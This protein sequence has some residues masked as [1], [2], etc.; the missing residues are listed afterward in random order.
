[1]KP[2]VLSLLFA[3]SSVLSPCA[4][5]SDS[6]NVVPF[7][8]NIK[9]QPYTVHGTAEL[10]VFEMELLMKTGNYTPINVPGINDYYKNG[11]LITTMSGLV[12]GYVVT[13]GRYVGTHW[14][15][16][17]HPD[18][19]PTARGRVLQ[20]MVP[21]VQ[22]TMESLEVEW[23][24]V[25]RA[26]GAKAKPLTVVV[27]FLG[28]DS[29]AKK[30]ALELFAKYP[31]SIMED[32]SK[33]TSLSFEDIRKQLPKD[34]RA[35]DTGK[36]SVVQGY[37]FGRVYSPNLRRYMEQKNGML[38]IFDSKSGKSLGA[39]VLPEEGTPKIRFDSTQVVLDYG[40]GKKRYHYGNGEYTLMYTYDNWQAPARSPVVQRT[41]R[42]IFV[43]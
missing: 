9:T 21:F 10:D 20:L 40:P 32:T 4:N 42:D 15:V 31:H 34:T 33:G 28:P 30:W 24:H 22:R 29:I 19:K 11:F 27:D 8:I 16:A 13:G 35:Q 14:K 3:M 23:S 2:L 43:L 36:N 39:I 38:E 25:Q 1:M 17:F 5:A 7:R 26:N 6:G 37:V 41:C 18:M 12:V